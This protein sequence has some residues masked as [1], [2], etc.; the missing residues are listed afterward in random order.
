MILAVKQCDEAKP[1]FG[2]LDVAQALMPAAS[3]LMPTLAF[4]TVSGPPTRVETSLDAAG[5]S[6]C[7]TKSSRV[8]E[9]GAHGLK[10][11]L[12]TGWR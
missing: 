6:A 11:G 10:R 12:K 7:A 4:A 1:V 2:Y 9:D 3:A 8:R 5:T